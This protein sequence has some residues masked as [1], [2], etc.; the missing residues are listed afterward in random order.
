MTDFGEGMIITILLIM[1]GTYLWLLLNIQELLRE[2]AEK[3][4]EKG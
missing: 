1:F 3:L 2:I 4:E